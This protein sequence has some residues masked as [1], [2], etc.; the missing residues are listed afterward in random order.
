MFCLGGACTASIPPAILKLTPWHVA[1]LALA[2]A[3]ATPLRAL[4]G[5]GLSLAPAS[6]RVQARWTRTAG[7]MLLLVLSAMALAGGTYNAFLY[8]RF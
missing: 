2:A 6:E 8:F 4:L 5:A 1:W 3:L 7:S